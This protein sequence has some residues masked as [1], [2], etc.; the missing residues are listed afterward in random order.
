MRTSLVVSFASLLLAAAGVAWQVNPEKLPPPFATPSAG[1]GPRVIPRPAGAALKTP[2]GFQIEEYASGFDVP[3]FMLRGSHGVLL[4]ET[5]SPGTV[6][7][8]EDG[9]DFSRPKN[10]YKLTEQLDRPYGMAFWKDY[11]YVAETTSVKRFKYDAETMKVSGSGE[12]VVPMHQFGSGHWTRTILFD[13]AGEKLYLSI[14]SASNDSP[15]GD[16]RR[17]AVNRYNPDGTGQEIFASG[18]RNAVGLRWFPDSD[19]LWATCQERDGL[20]NDLPPDFFTHI[21]QGGFYGWPYAYIG[22]NTDP[23]NKGKRPDLVKKTIGPG[24]LLG[25]H[26][27]ALDFIFYTGKQ[28]PAEYRDGAFIALHGSWNRRPRVGYKIVFVPFK[29]G[30]P[31]SGPRDFVSGFMLSPEK[32]EVWG[33]P[34][35][36]VE[37]PDGSVLFSDDGGGTIWR[38]SYNSREMG[39]R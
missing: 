23:R 7:V 20:G 15:G 35:G 17:A 21:E 10:R 28:F 36:L 12:E 14:G 19:T 5:D 33:R 29:N 27:S 24:V 32:Q 37:L 13:R 8:L 30:K 3:R 18:L 16:P 22:P 11:L 31:E 26:V 34:V 1:N 2:P 6:W 4:S 9:P 39:R 38:V 25:A